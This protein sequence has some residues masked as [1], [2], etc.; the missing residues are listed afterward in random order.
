MIKKLRHRIFFII[1]IS[2]SIVIIGVI[3]LFTFF[4]YTNTIN[5][6]T[7]MLDKFINFEPRKVIAEREDADNKMNFNINLEGIY[8][9]KIENSKI[10]EASDKTN[11]ETIAQY[12]I[13]ISNGKT[14]NG[15]IGDYIYKVR[16]TKTN[17]TVI[18]MENKTVVTQI[19]II[20]IFSVIG[21]AISLI[22]IYSIAKKL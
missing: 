15:V 3:I 11:N 12:A 18:L 19:K 1:M 13:K 16:R 4:N 2:L 22:I 21:S 5:T 20:I 14:E 6:S 10:I 7:S 9:F 17:N 8:T